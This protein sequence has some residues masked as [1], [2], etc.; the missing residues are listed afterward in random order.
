MQAG[1][2]YCFWTRSTGGSWRQ[3]LR[4]LPGI[5]P[6]SVSTKLAF[7]V[8]MR[9]TLETAFPL[10]QHGLRVPCQRER[11]SQDPAGFDD[12]N[13]PNIHRFKDFFGVGYVGFSFVDIGA[14]SNW[15]NGLQRWGKCGDRGLRQL[16]RFQPHYEY[17]SA[18]AQ[19]CRSIR[20]HQ[21]SALGTRG[22]ARFGDALS[23]Q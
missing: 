8:M 7:Q 19:L 1:L 5:R 21:F 3:N 18:A 20:A 6:Q 13:P 9:A 22:R 16:A 17:V 4:K 23:G 2:D 11:P 15:P 14:I 12:E 10:S